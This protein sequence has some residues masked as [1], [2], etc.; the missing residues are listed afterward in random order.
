MKWKKKSVF[1]VLLFYFPR[2]HLEVKLLKIPR[3]QTVPLK[4]ENLIL[5][6]L[7]GFEGGAINDTPGFPASLSSELVLIETEK[8][9]HQEF[10]LYFFKMTELI[11][12]NMT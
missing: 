8:R 1:W 4:E 2:V 11:L 6:G 3:Y 12:E 9:R 10:K 7:L 5:R